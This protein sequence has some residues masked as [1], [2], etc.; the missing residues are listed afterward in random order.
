MK[1]TSSNAATKETSSDT[2]NQV[3][4]SSQKPTVA[5]EKSSQTTPAETEVMQIDT[6]PSS[7][8]T[9]SANPPPKDT[10]ME[11]TIRVTRGRLRKTRSAGNR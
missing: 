9:E 4:G 7:S 1:E 3:T 8:E 5:A 2:L 10:V 6:V 11:E